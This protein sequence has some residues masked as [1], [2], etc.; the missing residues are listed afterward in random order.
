MAS[1]LRAMASTR[2]VMASTLV[3]MASTLV[4][5][6]QSKQTDTCIS[7]HD[8]LQLKNTRQLKCECQ[9][10]Q[11]FLAT[12]W[13]RVWGLHAWNLSNPRTCWANTENLFGFYIAFSQNN[14]QLLISTCLEVCI[15]GRES[16]EVLRKQCCTSK[17]GTFWN[18]F[19]S[20]CRCKLGL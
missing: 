5:G 11:T 6:T 3:T 8:M 15:L 2:V 19:F 4:V 10:L 7:Q 13:K 9:H 14:L 17:H 20:C 12:R 18:I 1:I 16:E